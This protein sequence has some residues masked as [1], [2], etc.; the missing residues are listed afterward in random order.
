MP[1]ALTRDQ[2][3]TK[4]VEAFVEVTDVESE[5]ELHPG[6]K[7]LSE[8]LGLT[9]NNLNEVRLKLEEWLDF[10]YTPPAEGEPLPATVDEMFDRFW[11]FYSAKHNPSAA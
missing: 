8:E 4:F 7:S 6:D 9:S 3:W 10:V 2:A 1:E 11:R 5:E